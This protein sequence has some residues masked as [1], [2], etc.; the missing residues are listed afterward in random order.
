MEQTI[1]FPRHTETEKEIVSLR[2][3]STFNSSTGR[4]MEAAVI[5]AMGRDR[6]IGKEGTMPWHI[7]ADLKRFKALTMG[8][9]VIMGRHTWMSLPS[10]ALPGR[11]NIVVTRDASFR[12][13]GAETA[14]S[15]EE[16][17]G[18]CA[19]DAFPFI[20]GGGVLYKAMLP[21][22]TRLYLTLVDA[23]YPDADTWFPEIDRSEWREEKTSDAPGETPSGLRYRFLNL[24]RI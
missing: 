9:P 19:D 24:R 12:A 5:V 21:Y 22:A 20:I 15:P 23:S 10:G 3:F 4:P 17:L 11:R 1:A 6:S 16:A 8:H 14:S 13:Q 18:M 7:S 2:P